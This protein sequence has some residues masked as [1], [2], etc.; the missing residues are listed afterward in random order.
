LNGEDDYAEDRRQ[1]TAGLAKFAKGGISMVI[2]AAPAEE[3][4]RSGSQPRF[5]YQ[6]AVPFQGPI[7]Q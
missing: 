3:R 4:S 2:N 1:S 6:D 7:Q 5:P